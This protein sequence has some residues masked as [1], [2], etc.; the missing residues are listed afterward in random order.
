MLPSLALLTAMAAQLARS[1]RRASR[2]TGC[3]LPLLIAGAVVLCGGDLLAAL[4]LVLLGL[5]GGAW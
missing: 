3:L 2:R 4:L 1:L 5:K